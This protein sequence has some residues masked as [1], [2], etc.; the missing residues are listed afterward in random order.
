MAAAAITWKPSSCRVASSAEPAI[1]FASW[2]RTETL[3]TSG[4]TLFATRPASSGLCLPLP[5]SVWFSPPDSRSTLRRPR[6]HTLTHGAALCFLSLRGVGIGSGI[7]TARDTRRIRDLYGVDGKYGDDVAR[8]ICCPAYSLAH[9]EFRLCRQEERSRLGHADRNSVGVP[10]QS[11]R[12]M[13]ASVSP[14]SEDDMRLLSPSPS[15]WESRRWEEAE[16]R[17]SG[18]VTVDGAG[19]EGSDHESNRYTGDGSLADNDAF[20]PR[21]EPPLPQT[22]ITMPV[23]CDPAGGDD[24]Q[25]RLFHPPQRSPLRDVDG[26][27]RKSSAETSRR[28]SLCPG[29]EGGIPCHGTTR[30]SLD[31]PR[32]GRP[33]DSL[34][35]PPHLVT[36]PSISRT[37]IIVSSPSSSSWSL[38]AGGKPC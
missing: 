25:D 5:V 13:E 4:T 14:E 19:A 26:I 3:L 34:G 2:K 35:M 36:S 22:S 10:Y 1:G 12:P 11:E 33:R 21:D 7:L 18:S 31:T 8:A 28:P 24:G 9:N 23:G 17:D 6:E 27:S 30:S 20:E 37:L 15:T 16:R 29:Q 38:P 32:Q